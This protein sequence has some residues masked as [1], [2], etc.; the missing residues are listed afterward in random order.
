MLISSGIFQFYYH[1]P[2]GRE[3]NGT[4]GLMGTTLGSQSNKR[5][6]DVPSLAEA[7]EGKEEV[8]RLEGGKREGNTK[9]KRSGKKLKK[10]QKKSQGNKMNANRSED[11]KRKKGKGNI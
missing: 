7:E 5:R 6:L 2:A 1:Y 11:R 8:S 3:A 9:V 10:V 4:W